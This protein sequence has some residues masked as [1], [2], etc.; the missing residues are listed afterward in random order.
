MLLSSTIIFYF[1]KDITII[2]NLSD[3]QVNAISL[4]FVNGVNIGVFEDGHALASKKMS[5]GL[6]S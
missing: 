6:Q 3:N 5:E 1:K 4:E 2:E